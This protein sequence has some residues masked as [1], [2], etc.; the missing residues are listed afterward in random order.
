MKVTKY[1]K[2]YKVRLFPTK[3]QEELMWK[4]IHAC[5]FIWNS[6]IEE[7]ESQYFLFSNSLTNYDFLRYVS[8]ARNIYDWLNEI[9]FVSMKITCNDLWERYLL[10]YNKKINFPKFRTKKHSK[11][12]FPIRTE[13]KRFYFKD[14][15]VKVEKIGKIRCRSKNIELLKLQDSFYNG[16]ISYVNNKWILSVSIDCESQALE[17][18]DKSIGIDLGIKEL[19]TCSFGGEQIVF[20]N[21][22]KS[23]RVKKLES[24]LKHIQ[25]NLERKYKKCRKDPYNSLIKTNNIIREEN[26]ERELYYHLTNIRN[27][28]IYKIVSCIILLRP[29]SIIMETL[30]IVG[31]V[32]NKN[33]SKY[34]L[35]A[36]FGKIVS[37]IRYK[38]LWNGIEFIQVPRFYPSSKTCSN[39]GCV[40]KDLK[41]SDRIY[42]C[43]ECGLVIDRDF[44][45]ARNLENYVLKQQ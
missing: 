33:L 29:K 42:I 11:K 30:N 38:C 10:F 31:L 43:T 2:G 16:R 45:A 9:S 6:M 32:K 24:K 22:N 4:H 39:C 7:I 27:D 25:R 37:T 40:K 23:R 26:I 5:R 14:N 19:A 21:I 20:H 3:E 36:K 1:F 41:L 8:E 34:I 44:N 28:Y 35:N 15:Y 17:L 12:S 18:T 13:N